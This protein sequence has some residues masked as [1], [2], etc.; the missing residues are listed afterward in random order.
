MGSHANTLLLPRICSALV[1]VCTINILKKIS[2][3]NRRLN[4]RI[5]IIPA[6]L[7]GSI[8]CQSDTRPA[9]DTT[10][11]MKQHLATKCQSS[12]GCVHAQGTTDEC[13]GAWYMQKI[14][15]QVYSNCEKGLIACTAHM[16]AKAD[17]VS[18]VV[19]LDGTL[20]V[21]KVRTKLFFFGLL[22][23]FFF[24]HG[25]LVCFAHAWQA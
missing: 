9:P 10:G 14:H 17:L 1:H 16:C 20:C 6:R 22:G 11:D 8:F 21:A 13:A 15:V 4:E 19:P 23:C 24:L 18:N 2:Q 25:L 5:Q 12:D 7:E 3:T